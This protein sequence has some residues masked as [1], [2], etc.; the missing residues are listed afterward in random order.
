[1]WSLNGSS[2][3][4]PQDSAITVGGPNSPIQLLVLQVHY[5]ENTRIPRSGDSSGVLVHY[6]SSDTKPEYNVGI[7]SLHNHG[8]GM[9]L[10]IL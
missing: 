3:N 7:F 4:F 2:V 1:M 8:V 5:I 9:K 10:Y 6:Y